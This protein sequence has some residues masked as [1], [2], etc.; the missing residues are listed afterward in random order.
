MPNTPVLHEYLFS[1]AS[2]NQSTCSS[3]NQEKDGGNGDFPVVHKLK[4]VESAPLWYEV[5]IVNYEGQVHPWHLHGVSKY[6]I[7][8]GF[9]TDQKWHQKSKSFPYHSGDFPYN[10]KEFQIPNW[11]E[12]AK[13]L[14]LADTLSVPPWGFVV[15]RFP[16]NNPGPWLFHCHLAYHTAN[17]GGMLMIFSVEDENGTLP[18]PSLDLA[19]LQLCGKFATFGCVPNL[20]MP[21]PAE[22][23][24][25]SHLEIGLIVS[26]ILLCVVTLYCIVL[27]S[28]KSKTPLNDYETI[29]T[30]SDRPSE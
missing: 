30:M 18:L 15:F 26:V 8:Y 11:Q 12:E 21:S 5:V 9:M 6:A 10:S 4:F 16:A 2:K 24:K 3:V 1:T 17:A 23:R 7:G 27:L 25:I 19:Q 13:V 20:A 28:M 14:A 29:P 22:L